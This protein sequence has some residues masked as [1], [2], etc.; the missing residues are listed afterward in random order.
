MAVFNL[1]KRA[2]GA[3]RT[4]QFLAGINGLFRKVTND[5]DRN[6]FVPFPDGHFSH[7]FSH[8][9]TSGSGNRRCRNMRMQLQRAKKKRF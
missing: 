6:F 3:G 2:G 4:D 1:S 7:F 5:S 8:V 9:Y